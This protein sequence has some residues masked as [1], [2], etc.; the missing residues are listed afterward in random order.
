MQQYITFG[1][2]LELLKNDKVTASYLS[3][4]YEISMRSV[5]RYLSEL[6]SAGIPTFSKP[7]KNGGIGLE[8]NFTLEELSL[9]PD[10]RYTLREILKNADNGDIFIKK[11][12]L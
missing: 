10:D 4:K 1:I 5:Y 9:S 8:R 6:E 2:L 12:N 11:L 3:K 7:G